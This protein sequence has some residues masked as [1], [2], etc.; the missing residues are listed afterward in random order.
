[1][2]GGDASSQIVNPQLPPSLG[3]NPFLIFATFGF[4]LIAKGLAD[5]ILQLN[6]LGLEK[7]YQYNLIPQTPEQG[8]QFQQLLPVLISKGMNVEGAIFTLAA[9]PDEVCE[10]AFLIAIAKTQRLFCPTHL[11][12][13]KFYRS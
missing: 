11:G 4:A 5:E 12:F 2:R 7:G 9:T 3:F 8:H 10:F 13:H 1:M 6:M